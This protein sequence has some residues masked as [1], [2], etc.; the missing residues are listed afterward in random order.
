MISTTDISAVRAGH[1]AANAGL[2]VG[3]DTK[4]TEM[5]HLCKDMQKAVQG[6]AARLLVIIIGASGPFAVQYYHC[7]RG[8][9]RVQITHHKL[10]P[11]PVIDPPFVI[12]VGDPRAGSRP[13][14]PA[15]RHIREGGSAIPIHLKAEQVFNAD[16]IRSRE[17][18]TGRQA[19]PSFPHFFLL[20]YSC[21]IY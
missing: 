21:C 6:T 14:V 8:F 10:I 15:M 13:D 19:F 11:V 3:P 12:K 4:P 16:M 7:P 20:L 1:T 18:A 9:S 17:L 5:H 2:T